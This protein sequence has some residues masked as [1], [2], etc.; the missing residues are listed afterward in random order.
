MFRPSSSLA[1]PIR[2]RPSERAGSTI[3]LTV[4]AT[5]S[6]DQSVALRRVPT[7]RLYKP[8]SMADIK[9]RNQAVTFQEPTQRR[10]GSKSM[11]EVRA[12]I[13][14]PTSG[15]EDDD[16]TTASEAYDIGD[17]TSITSPR[18]QS[19]TS[20]K[21]T[22]TSQDGD[23]NVNQLNFLTAPFD[24]TWLEAT[25]QILRRALDSHLYYQDLQQMQINHAQEITRPQSQQ[26][27][28]PYPQALF[29]SEASEGAERPPNV[30]QKDSYPPSTQQPPLNGMGGG[31]TRPGQGGP[32][33]PAQSQMRNSLLSQQPQWS[34]FEI[35]DGYPQNM[36]PQPQQPGN[37]SKRNDLVGTS[38]HLSLPPRN[39]AHSSQQYSR[40]TGDDYRNGDSSS[41]AQQPSSLGPAAGY[42]PDTMGFY[43]DPTP[44]ASPS[45]PGNAMNGLISGRTP[46]YF[47]SPVP[48]EQAFPSQH[49]QQ[50]SAQSSVIFDPR[51]PSPYPGSEPYNSSQISPALPI[52]TKF[53]GRVKDVIGLQYA[54]RP[55]QLE[56]N[57]IEESYRD[58]T[59]GRR[60]LARYSVGMRRERSVFEGYYLKERS[61][62]LADGLTAQ[63]RPSQPPLSKR[64]SQRQMTMDQE[65]NDRVIIKYIRWKRDWETDCM[66]L[67]YLTCP[68]PE[69][70][71]EGQ[72]VDYPQPQQTC[73][74]VSPYVVGLYETFIHTHGK[75][76]E[77]KYLSVL[78]WYSETLESFIKDC[79]ASGEGLEVTLPIIRC[80]I[81]CVAYIHS[82]KICH[83]NIKTSNFV[84]DPYS[85]S[86]LD[87]VWGRGWKLI[88]FE[89]AR[90][91]DEES[92]GRCTYQYAAPEV[93]MT[94]TRGLSITAR[95]SQDIWSLGLVIYELLTDK[96][97]FKTEEQAK[98]ALL[99]GDIGT[100]PGNHP[101]SHSGNYPGNRRSMQPVRYYDARNVHPAYIPLLDAML[102]HDPDYRLLAA[103]LLKLDL[104]TKPIVADLVPEHQWL[105]N[106]TIQSLTDMDEARL[107]S[108]QILGILNN[109]HESVQRQ[110]MAVMALMEGL[111]RILDSPFDQVPRLFML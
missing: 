38:K 31:G 110:Q 16:S 111:G 82:R 62:S 100:H 53:T 2:R 32:T 22:F 105:R 103:D 81:E 85:K 78:Q 67:R 19:M 37:R 41:R 50:T 96:P 45:T 14:T 80:L 33:V 10:N 93:L 90:I 77:R 109:S 5:S 27:F 39:P 36:Q 43:S 68:H 55:T 72:Y 74:N 70:K 94:H 92:L 69:E 79:I 86:C 106:N 17:K 24:P 71:L 34:K 4:T 98:Q 49:S 11:E 61:P 44:S 88:D 1:N 104:F 56:R 97:L 23:G 35:P 6:S 101:G 8:R 107:C 9:D 42:L 59:M 60:F 102:V 84:R 18:P 89:G 65:G 15:M 28:V 73:Q 76:G 52:P 25:P 95:A 47:T 63:S 21:V 75:E 40:S 108:R 54:P 99:N 91:M 64:P 48:Q 87:K 7:N 20:P 26:G 29:I 83:L 30:P 46:V 66:M 12:Q 57:E 3:P 58:N 51:G 13:V